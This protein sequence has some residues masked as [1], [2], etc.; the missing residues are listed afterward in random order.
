MKVES[1]CCLKSYAIIK[2]QWEP[3]I[4]P[5]CTKI[6][7]GQVLRS[8]IFLEVNI[9]TKAEKMCTQFVVQET[10]AHAGEIRRRLE[11][12]ED[13][14]ESIKDGEETEGHAGEIRRRFK[15]YGRR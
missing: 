15:E 5:K 13:D 4:K 11:E 14:L 9:C 12:L 6:Y 10:E 2:E 8:Y 7:T 1:M 3:K